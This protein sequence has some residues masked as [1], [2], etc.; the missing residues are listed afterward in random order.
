[1]AL[2]RDDLVAAAV[3]L[4]D[5]AGLEGLTLRR[6]AGTLGV[7]APTLYWHV[8]DKRTLLDLMADALVAEQRPPLQPAPGQPW[9]D[10]L[11]EVGEAQ[12]RA[13]IGHR[14]AGLVVAGNRPPPESLPQVERLVTSIAEAGFPPD[15]ALEVLLMLGHFVIGNVVEHQAE[16]ARGE[17]PRSSASVRGLLTARR[18]SASD[19]TS[20]SP[21]CAPGSRPHGPSAERVTATTR[22]RDESPVR[23]SC[24]AP[25]FGRKT[26]ARSSPWMSYA[27]E[28]PWS[29]RS[30]RPPPAGSA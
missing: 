30:R 23:S 12:Y 13:L 27:S 1:M 22:I 7:S 9:Q 8:K 19:S 25:R 6:L 4:L 21:G 18:R 10:W 20:S 17:H 28:P 15:E 24:R 3:R 16:A 11:R 29:R 14:D 5:E 2:T 26:E